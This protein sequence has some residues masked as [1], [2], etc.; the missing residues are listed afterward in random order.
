[1]G[2]L[3]VGPDH[4]GAPLLEP[5]RIGADDPHVAQ[6]RA[7]AVGAAGQEE[8]AVRG[9]GQGVAVFFVEIFAEAAGGGVIGQT[10]LGP[11]FPTEWTTYEGVFVAPA[12][13]DFLTF[14]FAAITGAVIGSV[15]SYNV[16]NAYIGRDLPVPNDTES[17]SDLKAQYR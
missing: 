2:L 13:T 17:W 8:A 10:L 15:S 3:V 4:R 1:V 14:Q 6:D 9:L 16:D 11:F 7:L 5:R 12:N